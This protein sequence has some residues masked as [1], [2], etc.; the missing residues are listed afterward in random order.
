M[1]RD[2]F[3]DGIPS[4]TRIYSML[5]SLVIHVL[6]FFNTVEICKDALCCQE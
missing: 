6:L 3:T 5:S 2:A 4:D 1:V